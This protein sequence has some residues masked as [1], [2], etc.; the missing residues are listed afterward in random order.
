M[1]L[2]ELEFSADIGTGVGLL[3]RVLTLCYAVLSRSVLSDSL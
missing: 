1:C 3:N 2:F